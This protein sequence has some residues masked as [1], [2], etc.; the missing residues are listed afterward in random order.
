MI[1]TRE[2]SVPSLDSLIKIYKD[3]LAKS[4]PSGMKFAE[5]AVEK[6][7]AADGAV[8]EASVLARFANERI[9]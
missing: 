8:A 2:M 1:E 6:I 4:D 5:S 9:A 3:A 7:A